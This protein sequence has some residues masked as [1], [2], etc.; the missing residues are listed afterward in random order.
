MLTGTKMKQIILIIA[1]AG[2]IVS[3]SPK[4]YDA[5]DWQGTKITVDGKIPEW[6]SPL[7]FYD[8]KTKINYAIS[9]DRRNIYVCMK[10]FDESQQIKVLRGGMEFRID[11]AGKKTVPIS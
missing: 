9:N 7:R 4:A 10:I 1:L 3:C 8:Y 2:L 5:L 6:P 11:T